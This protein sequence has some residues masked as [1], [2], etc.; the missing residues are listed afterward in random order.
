MDKFSFRPPELLDINNPRH[1]HRWCS[2][3]SGG[4]SVNEELGNSFLLDGLRNKIKFRKQYIHEI[5]EYYNSLPDNP[6]VHAI[7]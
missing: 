5:Q 1:Y 6:R 4:K 2:I 7:R 3:Q